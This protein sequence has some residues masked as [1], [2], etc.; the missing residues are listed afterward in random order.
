[1]P[2]TDLVASDDS[3]NPANLLTGVFSLDTM[4]SQNWIHAFDMVAS[5]CLHQLSDSP[6]PCQSFYVSRRYFYFHIVLYS[7]IPVVS[8]FSRVHIMI[9][10]AVVQPI[11]F[12]TF[13]N[14]NQPI[15]TFGC[16]WGYFYYKHFLHVHV[17]IFLQMKS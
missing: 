9:A 5:T 3:I 16:N 7:C 13:T 14:Y 4:L 11:A 8:F 10:D 17:S 1:M 12:T 2:C 6:I 15:T